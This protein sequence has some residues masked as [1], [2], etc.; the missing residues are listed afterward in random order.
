MSL[1]D[2]VALLL[3]LSALLGWINFR[4]VGLPSSIGMLVMSLAFWMYCIAVALVRVRTII[5]ERERHTAW[6]QKAVAAA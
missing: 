3:G 4:F 6:V 1:F 5:L 2:L